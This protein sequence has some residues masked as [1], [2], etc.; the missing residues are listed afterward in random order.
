[1]L[2]VVNLPTFLG[3]CV[4]EKIPL[5]G[6]LVKQDASW[7]KILTFSFFLEVKKKNNENLTVLLFS[8]Q[9]YFEEVTR[10]Q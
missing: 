4:F 7:S 2:G 1:M 9:K 3:A 5:E 10:K 6:A 8:G